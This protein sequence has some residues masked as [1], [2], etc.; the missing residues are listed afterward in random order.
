[1]KSHSY[2]HRFNDEIFVGVGCPTK[3]LSSLTVDVDSQMIEINI[4]L[5][6]NISY[7]III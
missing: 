7:L 4:I 3:V 6:I 5:V 1:M 2:E